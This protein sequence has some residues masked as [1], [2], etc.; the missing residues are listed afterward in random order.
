[1]S[2]LTDVIGGAN[3]YGGSSYSYTNDRFCSAYSAIYF[4]VGYLQVPSGVYF[5]GMIS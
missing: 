2:N 4:N 3:M 1:M 5:S